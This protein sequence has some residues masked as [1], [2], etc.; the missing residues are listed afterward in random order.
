MIGMDHKITF[1]ELSKGFEKVTF[2]DRPPFLLA[3][4][5][6]KTSSSLITVNLKPG[7][8]KLPLIRPSGE[9]AVPHPD[10]VPL[11]PE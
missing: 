3:T 6:P 2:P 5:L 1:L 11:H 7:S 10:D 8:W 9:P 4:F